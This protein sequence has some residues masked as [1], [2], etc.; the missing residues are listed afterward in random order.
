MRSALL[1]ALCLPSCL[2]LVRGHEQPIEVTSEPPG[3]AVTIG[4]QTGLT[5]CVLTV[6]RSTARK[7]LRVELEG[8]VVVERELA[9]E[10]A[11]SWAEMPVAFAD[12][13]LIV[14]WVIDASFA[15]TH[16]YP[17]R[18]HVELAPSGLPIVTLTR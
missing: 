2:T 8:H 18:V 13:L 12:V 14:P 3:A 1:L 10:F 11:V 5:P 16:D 15:A 4:E 9:S 6:D 17:H 7:R